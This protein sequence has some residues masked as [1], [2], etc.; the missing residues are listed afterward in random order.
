MTR[1]FVRFLIATAL[2]AFS[3]GAFAATFPRLEALERSLALTPDQKVQF[4]AAA[5]ATQRALIAMG[6]RGIQMK[7]RMNAE[8]AKERPDLEAL[9]LLREANAEATRPLREAARDEWLR[10]YAMLSIEQVA[11]VKALVRE[12]LDHL[13]A[14]HEFMQRLL[15]GKSDSRGG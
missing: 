6:I 8:F 1:A 15:L 14:L 2:A 9:A 4:D 13:D 12:K 10:L 5:A 7:L 3:L 11:K